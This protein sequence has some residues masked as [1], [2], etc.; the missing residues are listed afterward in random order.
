MFCPP[1]LHTRNAS[2]YPMELHWILP[3]SCRHKNFFPADFIE[4]LYLFFFYR[5]TLSFWQFDL[6]VLMSAILWIDGS[7]LS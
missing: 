1:S 4:K 5:H 2:K 3:W 6:F 7:P